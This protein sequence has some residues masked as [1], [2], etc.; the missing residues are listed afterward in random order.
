MGAGITAGLGADAVAAIAK[1][2]SEDFRV[3]SAVL[4]LTKPE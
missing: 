4:G 1:L 3:Q 2:Q